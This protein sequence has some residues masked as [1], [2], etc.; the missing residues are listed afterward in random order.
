MAYFLSLL[1]LLACP[2]M[3]GLMMWM[4]RGD[5]KGDTNQART[6]ASAPIEASK[7]ATTS[8][9]H[10]CLNWKVVAGLAVVGVGIWAVAPT[11]LWAALP[12][13]IVLA[14]PLSM[15]FMMRGMGGGQCAIQSQE[16]EL[17]ATNGLATHDTEMGVRSSRERVADRG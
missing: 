8:G 10:L 7:P 14:C 4:M 9:M 17:E 6:D 13:L 11:M 5:R 3:M 15:L 12:V 1:P 16:T 2:L